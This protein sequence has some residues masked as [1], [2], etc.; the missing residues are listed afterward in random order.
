M[1]TVSTYLRSIVNGALAPFGRQQAG[2]RFDPVDDLLAKAERRTGLRDWGDPHFRDGL[3]A[4]LGSLEEVPDLT[5]LGVV[6]FSDIICQALVSRLRFV[7]DS[8]Q[9]S[10][11]NSPVIITGLPRSGTTALHRL[12]G[13]DPGF[14]SPPLWELRDPFATST[15]DLRRWRTSA[16]IMLKNRLLPDLDRKHF[17]RADTPEECTLLLANSFASPLFWDLAPLDGYLEWY[18][19][20]SQWPAYV[21]YRRQLEVLQALHPDQRLLLK[22]P[23]H[24]GNLAVLHEVVPEALLIQTHRDPTSCFFSHCSLRETL[25]LFV[26]DRPSR[27]DITGQVRRVFEYDLGANLEFHEASSGETIH[28]AC[29]AV[30]NAPLEVL[31][32]LHQSLDL[33]WNQATAS[34]ATTYFQ[35]LQQ[36]HGGPH[37]YS[38]TDWDIAKESVDRLFRAYRTRFATAIAG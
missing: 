27:K 29:S 14:Y 4:L 23:A 34:R 13:L 28:V 36:G 16:G 25:G 8:V 20:T 18:Q 11:L 37:H 22:A 7:R 12:L 9:R 33:E 24:L 6:T 10:E 32:E 31:R 26:I 1:S 2:E 35:R 5:P 38:Y 19:S 17:T 3:D 21:D 15:F 30:R